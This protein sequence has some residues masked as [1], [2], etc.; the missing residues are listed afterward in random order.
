MTDNT[1]YVPFEDW[2]P[3][4]NTNRERSFLHRRI[5]ENKT[6]DT[7]S[8]FQTN[9]MFIRTKTDSK[10]QSYIIFVETHNGVMISFMCARKG[11]CG[12]LT[13]EILRQFWSWFL[14]PMIIQCDEEMSIIDLCR[15]VARE[16]NVRTVLR[17]ASKTSHHSNAFVEAEHGQKQGLAPNC[18][19]QIETNTD[20]QLS[21]ISSRFVLFRF[22]VR[23]EDKTP[24]P[25]FAWNSICIFFVYACC[26]DRSRSAFTQNDEQVDQ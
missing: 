9:Y 25:I 12:D 18:Q 14:N 24:F 22:T 20:W 26:F 15:R 1:T 4:C 6:A 21:T 16:R 3:I 2:C 23:P 10:T 7:L 11:R 8:K 19:T 17:F 13:K 5:V